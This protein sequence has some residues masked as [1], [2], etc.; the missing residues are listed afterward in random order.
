VNIHAIIFDF[1]G[2]ILD[3]ETV[4][5]ET[6]AEQYRAHGAEL[7]PERWVLGLGTW[8]GYDP[9]SEL[10]ALIGRKLDHS[11]L[12]IE[13]RKQ[14][15]QRCE[16][17]P[18]NPGVVPLLE[19][20]RASG[21]RTAVASSSSID[22]VG[23]W[24]PKHGIRHYFDCVRTRNDVQHVKPAPDLFLSAA[25]CLEIPPEQC[26]VL[27]DSPNGMR[28]AASAGMRC[29]AVPVALLR[30]IELPAHTMRLHSLAD[31]PPQELVAALQ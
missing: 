11:A 25:A 21:I 30:S 18:L 26:V 24:L 10:E 14:Y 15:L 17:L 12:Q 31:L 3:T 28:A 29:V 27:E 19:Y 7:L 16:A 23:H 4:E 6:L 20:C 13:H 5:F 22:W 1:D 2:L 8:G 9:Y